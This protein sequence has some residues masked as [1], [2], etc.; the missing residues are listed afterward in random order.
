M[1]QAIR[2]IQTTDIEREVRSFL[3][4][5][6]LS[7]RAEKLRADGSLLGNVIDSV[8]VLE[9]V[10]FLQDRFAIT[11]EDEEVVPGNL[12]TVHNL[13]AYIAGKIATKN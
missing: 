6:F 8:G 11:V 1:V 9:L 12:D 10:T 13:V 2:A 5:H 7:D 3:V 4:R